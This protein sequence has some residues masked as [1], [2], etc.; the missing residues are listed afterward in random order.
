MAEAA[1]RT[2]VEQELG[3]WLAQVNK[4]LSGYEQLQMIVVSPE[5]W[6]V[7]NGFLTPTLKIKRSKIEASVEPKLDGWYATKG[8]VL[9]G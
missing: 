4:T 2:R 1:T 7:E 9:W 3:A 8:S 6:A 5:P